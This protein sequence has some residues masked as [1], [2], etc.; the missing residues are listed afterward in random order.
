MNWLQDEKLVTY[1][2]GMWERRQV[3][4]DNEGK[5]ARVRYSK[6]ETAGEIG[7]VRKGE[8]HRRMSIVFRANGAALTK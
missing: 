6:K 2:E 3:I 8:S 7:S 1:T 4:V 5:K